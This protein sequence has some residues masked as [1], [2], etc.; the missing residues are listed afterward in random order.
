MFL[1]LKY[2]KI[3]SYIW[4]LFSLWKKNLLILGILVFS[5]GRIFAYPS[6]EYNFGL[7]L[8]ASNNTVDEFVYQD[9]NK[10]SLLEWKRPVIPELSLYGR[11]CFWKLLLDTRFNFSI[12][13]KCGSLEDYDYLSSQEK[14]I[15]HYSWHE[16]YTDKDFSI[17]CTLGVN[18]LLQ[19]RLT[20]IPFAGFCYKNKK[21]TAQNGYLQYP[22][23]E[24]ELWNSSLAKQQTSGMVIAYEQAIWYPYIGLEFVLPLSD[25]AKFGCSCKYFS[26]VC[27]DTLDSHILRLTQ[28]YDSMRNGHIFGTEIFM[29][30]NPGVYQRSKTALLLSV[31]YETLFCRGNTYYSVIGTEQAGF[32]QTKDSESGIND[33]KLSFS[34]GFV[35]NL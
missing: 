32:I 24:G 33:E 25:F 29:L 2:D 5:G 9:G 6:F 13:I 16:L 31:S 18:F 7:S 26:Y 21:F 12:P 17:Q 15:S 27:V 10:I 4:H 19:N 34:V 23:Y 1:K 14:R 35:V 20:F 8:S 28:F 11:F 3:S 22:S 30:I